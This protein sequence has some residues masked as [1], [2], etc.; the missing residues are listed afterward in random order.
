MDKNPL[1]RKGLVVG[2]IVLF[3][4][5]AVT[6]TIGSSNERDDSIPPV[7]TISFN[8]PEPDGENGWYVSDV[9]VILNATDDVSGVNITKY[10]IDE[11]PWEN[12]TESFILNKDG[13]GLLIEYFSI[14]NAGNTEPVKN[15]TLDIDRTKPL[16]GMNFTW[17][18]NRW[19]GY[20]FIYQAYA[21]DKM[22]GMNRVEFYHY[23]NHGYELQGIVT[24]PGPEY[25]WVYIFPSLTVGGLIRNIEITDDY[26]KFYAVIVRIIG[27]WEGWY[28]LIKAYAYDNAGNWDFVEMQWPSHPVTIVPGIFLFQNVTLPNNYTGYI[29]RFLIRAT[30]YN[31]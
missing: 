23:H 20:D 11:A 28:P 7:T 14:D 26:V 15:A 13:D 6:P 10:S 12:Y 9:T 4:G 19:R 5:I 17:E 1:I 22:S 30:F 29:G 18:G 16:V 2:I 25:T 3:I 27:I 24:G 31:S 8:P 21:I